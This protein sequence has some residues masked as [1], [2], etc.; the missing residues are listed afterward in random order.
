MN[1][2]WHVVTF[3]IGL[4]YASVVL[5]FLALVIFNIQAAIIFG[6]SVA[7]LGSIYMCGWSIRHKR[8]EAIK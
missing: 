8:G 1:W 7:L 3:F 2:K 4:R 6:F 5:A